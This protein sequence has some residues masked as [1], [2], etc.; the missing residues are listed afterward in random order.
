MP[1]SASHLRASA[2][3]A[4]HPS[5]E[6][7]PGPVRLSCLDAGIIGIRNIQLP[8]PIRVV[9]EA[10]T[11]EVSMRGFT[12]AVRHGESR[13]IPALE[14]VSLTLLRQAKVTLTIVPESGP[15]FPAPGRDQGRVSSSPSTDD[16]R[17]RKPATAGISLAVF[18]SPQSDWGLSSA[19]ACLGKLDGRWL[20]RKLLQE[21]SSLR[22][23]VRTQRLSRFVF[24]LLCS[25]TQSSAASYGFTDR[26]RLENA[27][28]DQFGISVAVLARLSS[29]GHA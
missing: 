28:Y 10:G 26:C 14:E 20:S 6:R 18:T 8:F 1:I 4:R 2:G 25:A 16:L 27:V 3:R 17:Q 29:A 19:A 5:I 13:L 23:L 21:C 7:L 15:G 24:D 12:R 22:Q 9:V 11:C